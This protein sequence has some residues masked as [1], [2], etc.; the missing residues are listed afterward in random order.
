[1]ECKELKLTIT[2]E[3]LN[4]LAEQLLETFC[5]EGM[6]NAGGKFVK[7]PYENRP[8]ELRRAKQFLY[9]RLRVIAQGERELIATSR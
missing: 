8:V 6:R 1:M 5:P 9:E 2:N 3:G 4:Y 7:F